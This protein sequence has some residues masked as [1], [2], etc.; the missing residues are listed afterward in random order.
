MWSHLTFTTTLGGRF[1]YDP[2]TCVWCTYCPWCAD[3]GVRTQR[4]SNSSSSHILNVKMGFELNLDLL[5]D[6]KTHSTNILIT[7][8]ATTPVPQG[9]LSN[10]WVHGGWSKFET[11]HVI[12]L[13]TG[14]HRALLFISHYWV[15]CLTMQRGGRVPSSFSCQWV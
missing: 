10:Q 1:C 7:F 8:V 11:I 15:F 12:T 4:L 2:C 5:Y 13:K 9:R 6:S 3:E 14:T